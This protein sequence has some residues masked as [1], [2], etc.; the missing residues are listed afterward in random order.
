VTNL[1]RHGQLRD[2]DRHAVVVVDQRDYA[3]VEAAF[4]AAAT[5]RV[6]LVRFTD[7]TRR[8]GK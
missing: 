8:G 7:A 4:H 6:V 2:L 5:F 3:R 1:V